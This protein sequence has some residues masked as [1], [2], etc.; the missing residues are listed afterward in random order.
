M[1]KSKKII[2]S[3]VVIAILA[4]VFVAN[5]CWY[6][7]N[8]D[9][10]VTPFKTSII[11]I[12]VMRGDVNMDEIVTMLDVVAT[13]NNI[14]MQP[15]KVFNFDAADL[16]GDG[17]ISMVDVVGIVNIILNPTDYSSSINAKRGKA[18]RSNDR[19]TISDVRSAA[20]NV[21]IPVS[22]E[23]AAAYTAFQMD[24]ELPEGATLSSATLGGRAAGNHRVSWST[25]ADGKVRIVAYSASNAAFAGNAGELLTLEVEAADGANGTI[26][27]D[28]IRMVTSEGI[29]N[30]ISACGSTIDINGTTGIG[31]AADEA[32]SCRYFTEAGVEVT[33]PQDGVYIAIIEYASGKTE[34][35]KVIIKKK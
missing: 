31:S 19:M 33:E 9:E 34:T 21:S 4:L 27:V 20:G 6:T 8:E 17:T 30:A 25:L 7:V 22:L 12:N 5:E 18:A 29:E 23:N 26:S 13:V 14:L 11:S 2:V 16:N 1:S 3:L 28:N 15:T 32:I 35:K 24:V 10:Y